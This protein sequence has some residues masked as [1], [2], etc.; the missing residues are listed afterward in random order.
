MGSGMISKVAI[1]SANVID[2]KGFKHVVP[3]FG[4]VYANKGYCDKNAK[5][6][7]AVKKIT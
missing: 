5:I 2:S 6:A 3:S 1:T 7:A 4:P